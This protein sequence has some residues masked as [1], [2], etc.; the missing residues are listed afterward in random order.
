MIDV[1]RMTTLV[2][3]LLLAAP[4]L[5]QE[6]GGTMDSQA[7]PAET[8]A[9]M[10][11]AAEPA[12]AARGE[13]ARA[14]FTTAV[15][16]REPVDQLSE[17]PAGTETVYFFTELRGMQGQTVTHR[18]SYNGTVMAEVSFDVRGPRWR[19]YS[20]KNFVPEWVGRWR[21]EVIDGGGNVVRSADLL[22]GTA[23]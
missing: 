10:A 12:P 21:V 16:D 19:V 23:P 15:Q 6:G 11:Q 14:V 3:A 9:E 20:S 13:V 5:A 18:W 4:A 17:V 7:A 22:Y 8:P 1:K 2:A